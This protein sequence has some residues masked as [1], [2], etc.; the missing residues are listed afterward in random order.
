MTRN[1]VKIAQ[2]VKPAHQYDSFCVRS[3]NDSFSL[4]IKINPSKSHLVG[5]VFVVAVDV[6][7]FDIV[8]LS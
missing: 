1:M 8:P 6:V 4:A 5:V 2:P 3:I 7:V